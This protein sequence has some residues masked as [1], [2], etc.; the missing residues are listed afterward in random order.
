METLRQDIRFGLRALRRNP[1]FTAIAL[2]T[3]AL[4]IGVNTSIFS[5]VNA[6]L[7]RPM[8]YPES[9]ELYM[10]WENQEL[11]GGPATEWT[12]RSTFAD[13][14][15]RS[16]TFSHMSAVTGW[17]PNLVGDDRPTVLQGAL[18]NPG[19]FAMLGAEPAIGRGFSAEE[20]TP[21][22]DGVIVLGYDLWQE[23]FGGD[24]RVIGTS[25]TLNGE[26]NVVIGIAPAGF[27]GPILNTA[28]IWG[29][30]PIDRSNDD[31]GAYFLQVIARARP[32][33]ATETLEADMARVAAGIAQENPT[34]YNDV[35]VTVQPLRDAVVGPIRT[36]L[37]VLLGTVAL[38]LLIACANVANLQLARASVRERELAVRASLGAGRGRIARQ[39]LTESVVLAVGGGLLGLALGVWGTAL[40]VQ[41]APAG[42]PRA[43]EIGLDAT[44][45]LFG[46]GAS[47][48]TGLLFGLAPALN[49]VAESSAQA[50]REGTRGSSTAA[51]GRLRSVLVIGELALG[52]TVLV[53]AGLLLR[54]FEEMR[55]VDPG[56]RVDN[57][58]SARVLLPSVDYPESENIP[59][60]IDQL[61]A[62]LRARPGVRAVGAT[63]VLPLGGNVNDVSFG[64]EGRLPE[65][66]R[67]PLADSWRVTPGYFEA[68]RIPL[69]QGRYLEATDRAGGLNV[70][71]VSRSLA[72]AHFEGADPV[73]KRLK[74]GG[75]RD[76]DSPWWTIVGVVETVRTRGIATATEPEIYVPLAQMPS[77]ALSLVIHTDG[78]P[79]GMATDLREA[80]W[81]LDANM[82]VSQVATLESVFATSI[83]PQRFISLLL[84][85]FAALALVLAAVGIYGVMAFMVSQRT[86]EIGVRM[87]LGARPNDV[88]ASVMSRGLLLTGLGVV[89]GLLAAVGAGRAL[90]TL[91][92]SV[93]PVDPI[94][95]VSVVT[96]LSAAAMFA[97]YWPARRATRVDP[98]I[99]LR[100]E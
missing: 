76:P 38:V 72:D 90:S 78:P 56:F 34:D 33:T 99:T 97:C 31:R 7:L 29:V 27:Q 51:G 48:L 80:V 45:F 85:A 66:G 73:G 93:S 86:R 60:F 23:R 59:A 100:A 52:V 94:T 32:G 22:N 89:V 92:F 79:A 50:L 75:V 12:G 91:L 10:L 21:G 4:G 19:Y 28:Q 26:P 39:L 6:V 87:A 55:N 98:I 82:P 42:L 46:L 3:I 62:R 2:I 63:N 8:S 69:I 13:W 57:A 61:E 30:L 43:N 53:A 68:M 16:E 58:L 65:P 24:E 81:A 67:E 70:A 14:R 20:E 37:L 49:H 95:L 11:R 83:A 71:V 15:D 36:P 17:A 5:V 44:V 54:S 47:V 88:L 1:G 96:L 77:R 9:G 64:I 41:L 35:G 25:L 18:V 40:L 84:G 74:V